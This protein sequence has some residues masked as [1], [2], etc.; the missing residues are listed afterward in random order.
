[1]E[2]TKLARYSYVLMA[3]MTEVPHLIP[4]SQ[5]TM[6]GIRIVSVLFPS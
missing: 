1:M 6:D 2:P 4:S 3:R 5:L